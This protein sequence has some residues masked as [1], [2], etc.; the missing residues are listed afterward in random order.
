MHNNMVLAQKKIGLLKYLLG[1]LYQNIKYINIRRCI[2]IIKV[3][4]EQM[5]HQLGFTSISEITYY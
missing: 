3:F 5:R 4:E 1:A 2:I